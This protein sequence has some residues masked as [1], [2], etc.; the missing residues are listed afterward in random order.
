MSPKLL[1]VEKAFSR[2]IAKVLPIIILTT[3]VIDDA[4]SNSTFKHAF[5]LFL[6]ASKKRCL[7][8]RLSEVI[9]LS[10][11]SLVKIAASSTFL[12]IILKQ[13]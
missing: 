13:A 6:N 9:M 8:T 12:S 11:I 7:T 2:D 3:S 10:G 4:M 5:S 1:T